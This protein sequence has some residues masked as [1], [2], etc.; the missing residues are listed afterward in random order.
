M[1]KLHGWRKE[2]IQIEMGYIGLG[3]GP[4]KMINI[5]SINHAAFGML[6][7]LYFKQHF[8]RRFQFEGLF[9]LSN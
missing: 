2:A 7:L 5:R 3:V 4:I 1:E 9:V 8:F 6:R